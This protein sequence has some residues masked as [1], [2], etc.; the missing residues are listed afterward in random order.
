LLRNGFSEAKLLVSIITPT[1]NSINYIKETYESIL[2]QKYQN[3]EWVITDDCSTDD[4]F[5]F[6]LQ[7]S[8]NDIRIRPF[9]LDKNSGAAVAQ[10]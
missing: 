2:E 10:K 3:W 8:I 5:D 9:K 6:L 7:L 1:F 4:T